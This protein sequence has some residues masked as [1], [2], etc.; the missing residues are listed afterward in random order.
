MSDIRLELD[1]A[2][3]ELD[4][5]RN[6]LLFGNEDGQIDGDLLTPLAKQEFLAAL[7]C[8][9]LAKRHLKMAAYHVSRG[10]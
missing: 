3:K 4:D 5:F 2:H 6:T 8:L 1:S 7:D 10:D 9:N